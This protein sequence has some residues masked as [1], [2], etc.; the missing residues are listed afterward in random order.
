MSLGHFLDVY[1]GLARCS[2]V[3]HYIGKTGFFVFVMLGKKG[4]DPSSPPRS[5]FVAAPIKT[6]R[7]GDGGSSLDKGRP[8][9]SQHAGLP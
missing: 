3:L 8:D 5:Y 1:N 9:G 2:P 4:R 6:H 7:S